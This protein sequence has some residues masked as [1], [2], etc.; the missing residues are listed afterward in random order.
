[1]PDQKD[2]F[3]DKMRDR[4]RGE[5]DRYFAEQDREKL[6]KLQAQAPTNPALGLCPR[7][8]RG[9]QEEDHRGVS[10]DTCRDCGGLWLD[11]GELER[12]AKL[13]EEG[14]PTTWFRAIF[15]GG[16]G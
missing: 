13:E 9:L 12:L 10:I 6:R 3:G 15:K 8:G 4:E 7:C 1:M 5:E 2:R 11:K 14:W 16:P